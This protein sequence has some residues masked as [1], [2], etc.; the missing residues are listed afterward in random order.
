MLLFLSDDVQ[1]NIV[2][3]DLAGVENRFTCS[4]SSIINLDEIYRTKS[5][6][7]KIST[8]NDLEIYFDSLMKDILDYEEGE[9]VSRSACHD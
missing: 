8:T 3:G 7:Y 9:W 4:P 6:R 5:D 2:V 1:C